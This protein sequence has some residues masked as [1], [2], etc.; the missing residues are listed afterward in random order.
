MSM[1]YSIKRERGVWVMQLLEGRYVGTKYRFGTKRA[2]LAAV[3]GIRKH[4]D[5]VSA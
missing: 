4:L 3:D 1:D 5:T 2:L